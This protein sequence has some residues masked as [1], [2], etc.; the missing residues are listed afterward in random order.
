MAKGKR[1]LKPRFWLILTALFAVV[2]VCVYSSQAYY[3][4]LQNETLTDLEARRES[5]AN[6][7]AALERK[8]DFI[9]TDEYI[10]REARDKLGLLMPGE[11]LFEDAR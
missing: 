10:I 9:D 8:L 6:S 11:I 7:K 1:T 4:R 5:L 2:A 3:L